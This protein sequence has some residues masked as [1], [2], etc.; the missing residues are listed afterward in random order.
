MSDKEILEKYRDLQKVI[1]MLY[2]YKN[3]FSLSNGIDT[4][5][6]LKFILQSTIFIRPYHVKEEDELY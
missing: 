2:K 1:E 5:P 3:A 4:Y 6:K